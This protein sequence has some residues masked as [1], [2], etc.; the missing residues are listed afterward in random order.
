MRTNV[1]LSGS[2]VAE[3]KSDAGACSTC[4]PIARQA[5]ESIKSISADLAK[6]LTQTV[7]RK[8]RT[9]ET[10]YCTHSC[11]AK[12]N[13]YWPF[14]FHQKNRIFDRCATPGSG[15]HSGSWWRPL[16][17]VTSN[18]S[19][20]SIPTMGLR[21]GNWLGDGVVATVARR[22][23]R[24]G[25]RTRRGGQTTAWQRWLRAH[26]RDYTPRPS[27]V[28]I[29]AAQNVCQRPTCQAKLFRCKTPKPIASA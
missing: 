1:N 4:G 9:Q 10:S 22:W 28:A 20:S 13:G 2:K 14:R 23:T 25:G 24:H 3:S 17:Q 19:E 11:K 6:M 16:V 26:Q 5:A 7:H 27:V 8:P 15:N 21:Q 29:L 12:R 18:L